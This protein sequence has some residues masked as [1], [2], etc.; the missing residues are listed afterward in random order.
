MDRAGGLVTH[1]RVPSAE[2][3]VRS[4]KS[5]HRTA[6]RTGVHSCYRGHTVMLL[7]VTLVG[8]LKAPANTP[9]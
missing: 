4:L 1:T 9:I 7:N 8:S 3:P 6:S 2:M 5:R